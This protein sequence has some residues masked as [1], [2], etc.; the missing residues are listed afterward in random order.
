LA[1][2]LEELVRER[3]RALEQARLA[4]RE[5]EV[6]AWLALEPPRSEEKA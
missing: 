5:P 4:T 3:A 1:R 2:R 6:Q